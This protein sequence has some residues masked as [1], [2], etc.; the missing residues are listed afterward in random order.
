MSADATVHAKKVR[1][2]RAEK[3]R[4]HS[5][6]SDDD[7][8]I[9][10]TTEPVTQIN[11]VPS[12]FYGLVDASESSYFKESESTLTLDTFESPE[13]KKLYIRG[14]FEEC[15]GKELKLVTNQ[16]TSKLIERLILNG[17]SRQVKSFFRSLSGQ[18]APLAHH[19]YASHCLET[20]F[21]RSAALCEKELLGEEEED[22]EDEGEEEQL[23]SSVESLF[24][25]AVRE[26]LPYLKEMVS[27]QYASHV[28]RVA[29]LIL[30]GKELPS[31]T[32]GTSILRSK[33]SKVAR[34][35][36]EIKDNDDFKKSFQVPSS[37]KEELKVALMDVLLVDEDT[38]S[39]RELSIGKISS[40][41]YQLII[42]LEGMIDRERPF[43]H[44][45]FPGKGDEKDEKEESFVE[46]LLSDSIGSH[47]LEA[48]AKFGIQKNVERLYRLYMKDRI[49]KLVR[50]QT[51]GLFVIEAMMNKLGKF[52]LKNML[53]QLVPDLGELLD[54]NLDLGKAIISASEKHKDFMK[55]EI[56]EQILQK[57]NSD[58]MVDDIL[59][60][61]GSTLGNTN[62]DWPTAQERWR[63]LFFERLVSYDV[64]LLDLAV[65]SFLK[66]SQDKIFQM[67]M[68]GVFSH[69]V[70]SV[71]VVT[72]DNIINR[73]K[74]LNCFVG[75]I[76]DLA[77]N[78]YGS[79]I[80][81]KFWRFTIKLKNY[82]EKIS[83]ELIQ[84]KER[85][86]E[87]NYGRI[88]WRNWKLDLFIRKR[89]DWNFM[90][91]EEEIEFTKECEEEK[92]KMKDVK[93]EDNKKRRY[94]DEVKKNGTENKTNGDDQ[95]KKKKTRGRRRDKK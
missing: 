40:P 50:R 41:V 70:E 33:K 2:R 6:N 51:T 91:K 22:P 4:N 72:H 39:L 11:E 21:I 74:L 64:K 59:K 35:M 25:Y 77:C 16:I 30:A 19:K 83:N 18:F 75:Q 90:V 24:L 14:V 53:Q 52:E 49:S 13:D 15:K 31:T 61:E 32:T 12:P 71:L 58:N 87:S 54:I 93:L 88:V 17:N 56:I 43:F 44:L 65:E 89:S 81:D 95:N 66:L 62:D 26:F 38:K 3:K 73:R 5:I 27:H 9:S 10:T 34:K 85:V 37:Y 86:K 36:I 82:K 7:A 57:Y 1:G 29:L 80:V 46:Y 79:H 69:A 94:E 60:L 63:T 8:P 23:Y 47:F 84:D 76:S 67:C 68:H 45:I 92:S 48:V 55:E 28:L 78:A 42:Q 20:L